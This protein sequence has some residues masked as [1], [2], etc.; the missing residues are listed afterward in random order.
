MNRLL[1]S[2][3]ALTLPWAN[4]RALLVA[5]AA[6]LA[7][8]L[9]GAAA[10]GGSRLSE[11]INLLRIGADGY[12]VAGGGSTGAIEPAFVPGAEPRSNA[13]VAPETKTKDAIAA[14]APVSRAAN[15]PSVPGGIDLPALDAARP[16]I[17]TGSVDITVKSVGD[18][19]DQVRLIA[20]QSG[21]LVASSSFTGASKQSMAQLTLRVPGERF[22]DVVTR[23][24]EMAVE[25][26]SISTGSQ[27]V[28]DQL[29]DLDATLRNL[30]AV[31]ARYMVLLDQARNI[32]EVLQ[33]QDRINQVR[34]QIDR[35]EARRQ[36]LN[37]QVEM[38][39]ISVTLRPIAAGTTTPE[40]TGLLERVREAWQASLEAL[41]TVATTVLVAIVYTWWMV[42]LAVGGVLALR[43]FGRTTPSTPPSA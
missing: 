10:V 29:T 9:L 14:G 33:V 39:T 31:E 21:G 22:G 28:A 3:F 18:A 42:V 34:L 7:V 2:N 41:E 35:T 15:A 26:Q 4:Q 37:A 27:D 5:G 38:S 1:H 12:Q 17:R 19:F 16:I 23:L 24:R 25:V 40:P 13:L 20:T 43:R 8:A 36:H 30:R 6:V 32:A 11:P